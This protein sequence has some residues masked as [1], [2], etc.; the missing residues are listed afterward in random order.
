MAPRR[1]NVTTLRDLP[2]FA[3]ERALSEAIKDYTTL[4]AIAE[5]RKLCRLVPKTRTEPLQQ[6]DADEIQRRVL[7]KLRGEAKGK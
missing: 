1:T 2:L 3:D 4:S 7:A 5:M 6:E